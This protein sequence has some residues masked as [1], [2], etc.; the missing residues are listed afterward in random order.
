MS[1]GLGLGLG[2]RFRVLGL[3]CWIRGLGSRV[4]LEIGLGLRVLEY[5]KAYETVAQLKY[6]DTLGTLV[7]ACV[8]YR[9]C[10]EENRHSQR[11]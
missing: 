9:A 6:W 4:G 11:L 3:V 8:D 5:E 1:Y 10:E 7:A 2:L